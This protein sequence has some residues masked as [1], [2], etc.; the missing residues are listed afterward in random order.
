MKK[1]ICLLMVLTLIASLGCGAFA[2][3]AEDVAGLL[4][5][6]VPP[7]AARETIIVPAMASVIIFCTKFFF[8]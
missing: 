6:A 2:E 8:I 1:M 3:A 5:E 7:Q 4:E